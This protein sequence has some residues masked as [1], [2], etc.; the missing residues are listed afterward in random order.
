MLPDC[1][2]VICK[3]SFAISTPEL[4]SKISC[5]KIHLRP[6]TDG[7]IDAL[8]KQSLS[9]AA[10]RVYNVFEDVLPKGTGAIGEIKE[11]LSD[12]SAL[13]TAMTGTGSAV[14]GIF[15]DEKSAAGAYEFLKALYHECY[16][17][18]PTGRIEIA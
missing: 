6:D 13:G 3:P 5:D 12:Y 11:K 7:I 18:E 17:T 16:L 2:I 4:F 10:R 1:R 9:G 14:F 15:Q 8:K